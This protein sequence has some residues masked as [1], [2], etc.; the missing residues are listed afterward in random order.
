M[1]ESLKRNDVVKKILTR[2]RPI[3]TIRNKRFLHH[4]KE[5]SPENAAS[6]WRNLSVSWQDPLVPAEQA[7]LLEDQLS[8]Y[9]DGKKDRTFDVLTD[10]LIRNVPGLDAKSVLE[11]GCSSGYHSEVFQIKGISSSYRGCDYSEVFIKQARL[12]YPLLQWDVADATALGYRNSEFDI[13]ISGCCILHIYN[14]EL[15]I[16][17]AARVGKDFVVF[18][19]TPVVEKGNTTYYQ[20]RAYGVEMLEIHFNEGALMKRMA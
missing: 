19:R 18:H 8:A 20:K 15:A 11:I 13:T 16:A 2:I 3:A 9:R 4:H 5:I 1:L 12:R 17:E 7:R 14:V 6:V 10:I